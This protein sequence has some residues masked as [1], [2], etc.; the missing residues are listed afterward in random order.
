M[1]IEMPALPSLQMSKGFTLD[2]WLKLRELSPGQTIL[3]ARD[4]AGKGIALTTS[5]HFSLRLTLSDGKTESVWES[6]YGTHPGT[7]KVNTW[8]HVAVIVDGGP[9]LISFVVDGVL[10]N[11]GSCGSTDG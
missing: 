2:F 11:E 10:N 5:D 7:L 9:K 4:K 1:T 6:D 3:D 8:Q